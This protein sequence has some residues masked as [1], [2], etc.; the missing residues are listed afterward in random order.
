MKALVLKTPGEFPS[1]EEVRVPAPKHHEMLVN[2]K[3]S[4]LNHRDIWIVKGKYPGVKFPVILGSDGSGID[5]NGRE[6]I[7]NP[8][9]DW[10]ENPKAQSKQF[11][12]LGLPKDGTFAE[13]LVIEKSQIFDKPT[14]LD[15]EQAAAL[16]LAGITAF[17]V[18]FS[19]CKAQAGESILITG[20][21]GG[22]ALMCL[23]FAIAAKLS[24]FV[25]SS[26]EEKVK[27]ALALGAEKGVIYKDENWQSKLQDMA[28]GFDIIIDSAGGESFEKLIKLCNPGG[29]IGIYGGSIGLV[30]NL[31]P[32]V[33]FW[34]QISILGST[35]GTNQEFSEMLKFVNRN[36]IVPSIDSIH[37]FEDYEKAFSKMEKGLQF[38][39]IVLR[40]A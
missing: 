22:V 8:G 25:T 24:V 7:I 10:G 17:R 1:I 19:R 18:L 4:A 26:S 15:F 31:S 9:L 20:I 30:N 37:G 16:P 5:E 36:K 3:A 27:R 40:H 2:L 11:N 32:Q 28:G 23:N 6:V 38:G 35:M 21:G 29:R 14:H 12:I 39:K 33:V 13:Y 34:R